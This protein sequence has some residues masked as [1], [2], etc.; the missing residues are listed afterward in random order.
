MS[1]NGG[2]YELFLFGNYSI[3]RGEYLKMHVSRNQFSGGRHAISESVFMSSEWS[4]V[5]QGD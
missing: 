4:F 5:A 1:N 3:F 2:F